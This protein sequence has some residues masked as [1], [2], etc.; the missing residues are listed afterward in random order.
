MSS[1]AFFALLACTGVAFAEPRVEA[2]SQRGAKL[3]TEQ[4]CIKCHTV[5]DSPTVNAMD[6]GRRLDRDYT[7]AGIASRMW[8]HAPVMWAEMKKRELPVP[9]VSEGQVADLFA[10]FYSAR[11][12]EK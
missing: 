5:G 11:Y 7:P 3:F 12:F 9:Q 8:N 4:Q 6:L 10:F 1:R 2:D